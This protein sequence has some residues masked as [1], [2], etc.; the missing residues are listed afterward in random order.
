[1]R[2]IQEHFM[3]NVVKEEHMLIIIGD[4]NNKVNLKEGVK[5]KRAT[6]TLREMIMMLKNPMPATKDA[7]P[8]LFMMIHTCL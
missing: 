4:L 1:M 6:Y 7:Y 8:Y 3:Q 2:K 5:K